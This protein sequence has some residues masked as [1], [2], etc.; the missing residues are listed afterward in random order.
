MATPETPTPPDGAMRIRR[1]LALARPELRNLLV[2]T[3]FL[4]IGAATGL[5]YPQAVRV[6]LDQALIAGDLD[7][8]NDA[9]AALVAVFAVQGLAVA[10]RYYLFTLAGERIVTRLRQY[11][12]DRLLSFEIGFFDSRRT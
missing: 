4:I 10:L 12:F 3:F 9:A 6:L 11:L 8:V 1:I 5:L 2:A 7:M